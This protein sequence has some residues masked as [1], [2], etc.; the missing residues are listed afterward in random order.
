MLIGCVHVVAHRRGCLVVDNTLA[1]G[2]VADAD[3]LAAEKLAQTLHA[4]NQHVAADKRTVA[5]ILP[6]RD[7][8]TLIR[9]RSQDS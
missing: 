3:R 7:G 2:W 1:R 6:M 8:I 4:F 9:Y 5:S